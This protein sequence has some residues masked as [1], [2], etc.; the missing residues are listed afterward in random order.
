MSIASLGDLVQP[1][2]NSNNFKAWL[3]GFMR[4]TIRQQKQQGLSNNLGYKQGKVL[5][6]QLLK[7]LTPL[8]KNPTLAANVM[9]NP[10]TLRKV[11]EKAFKILGLQWLT[12][13]ARRF[14]YN[15]GM[16]DA[17]TSA[18]NCS[19]IAFSYISDA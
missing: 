4:T 11:N 16:V 14:A 8:D 2:T 12:G 6:N 1:F 18:L 9:D 7:T 17:L 3:G 5:E 13:F 10:G 15:T 19:S